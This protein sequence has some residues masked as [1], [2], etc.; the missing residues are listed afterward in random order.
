MRNPF[1][2]LLLSLCFVLQMTAQS[3]TTEA[4][5]PESETTATEAQRTVYIVDIKGAITA[6]LEGFLEKAIA[7]AK[8][9][10]ADV[11]LLDINTFGGRVDSTLKITSMLNEL[12]DIE[13]ISYVSQSSDVGVSWSAGAIIAFGTDV[14]YMADG[15]SIGA[16][17]PVAQNTVTGQTTGTEEKT[18]SALRSKVV[19]LAEANGHPTAL[20]EAMVDLDVELYEV[21]RDGQLSLETMNTLNKWDAEKVDYVN[22]GIYL[23]KGKLLAL[24]AQEAVSFGLVEGLADSREALI[25]SLDLDV[26]GTQQWEAPSGLS[27]LLNKP[28]WIVLLIFVGVI[29]LF[30]ELA[31]PGVGVAGLVSLIAFG[32]FF[33]GGYV[34][35]SL[36]IYEIMLFLL[37]VMAFLAELYFL[38][39]FGLAGIVGSVLLTVSLVLSRIGG[40]ALGAG[41]SFSTLSLIVVV[42]A[43]ELLAFGAFL[44]LIFRMPHNRLFG[45]LVQKGQIETPHSNKSDLALGLEGTVVVDLKPTG[46]VRID[47]KTY[48]A[49]S[50]GEYIPENTAVVLV[51]FANFNRI[52][53]EKITLNT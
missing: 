14:I 5:A 23:E 39:G 25:S 4:Q 6:A 40:E 22:K 41:A 13:T 51:G 35:G 17:Q 19:A 1:L 32:L 15:T 42:V 2:I 38:P 46:R 30:V 16:A 28:V 31:V 36:S 20:A 44:F 45:K 12:T 21:E 43:S 52:I 48:D 34:N 33:F 27:T 53:V 37:A 50:S 7:N 24:T 11:L 9:I 3:E 47:G 49:V 29:A 26:V 18:V 8:A 10:N